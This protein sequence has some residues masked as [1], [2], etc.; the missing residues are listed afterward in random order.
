MINEFNVEKEFEP[1]LRTVKGEKQFFHQA[2]KKIALLPF[3]TKFDVGMEKSLKE[4][5]KSFDGCI[6]HCY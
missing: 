5:F 6:G 4:D 2:G 1:Y 3:S